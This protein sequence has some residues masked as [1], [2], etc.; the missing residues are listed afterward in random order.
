MPVTPVKQHHAHDFTLKSDTK[1]DNPFFVDL[2][3]TFTHEGGE[4]IENLPGFYDGDGAWKVRFAPTL[5]GKWT[6]V[7]ASDDPKLDGV[8]LPAVECA[9]NDNPA[10][11]GVLGTDPEYSHR[12]AWS[13][14][15]PYI[16]MG[17]ECDWLFAYHQ[18][19]GDEKFREAMDLVDERGFNCIIMNVYAHLGFS[20]KQEPAEHFFNP[21]DMYVFEGTNDEPDHGRLNLEFFQDFDQV[22]SYLHSKGIVAHL[23]IQVQNKSVKW[24]KRMTAED[25][26]YWRYVVARYQAY[27]N[28]VWDTSKESYNLL[29][30]FPEH[31]YVLDRISFIRSNDA[32]GHLVTVHDS[33]KKSWGSVSKADEATDFISDQIH[34]A[35]PD[36]Y[37][38][39][40]IRRWRVQHRPYVNLEYGYELGAEDIPTYRG[41][42]TA[43]WEKM[44]VW[45]YAIHAAGAYPG[46]YYNNTSWDLVK[47]WPEPVS[48]K[49]YR[50]MMDF[51]SAMDLR[52]MAPDN[53]F[54]DRGFCL[55]ELG[56]QYFIFCPDGGNVRLDLTAVPEEGWTVECT[57]LDIFTGER[58][59]KELDAHSFRA[60]LR[61]RLEYTTHPCAIYVKATEA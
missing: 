47:F 7:T 23:M 27:G 30:H 11:H 8:K 57:W 2:K 34:L 55:A 56:K 14:G 21:P 25:D 61:N 43:E 32:Y 29:K 31:A 10:V 19:A 39:E 38:R 45:T 36:A 59:S 58:A 49:R 42:T 18:R 54:V 13:D 48:W 51:L 12:F 5:Q 52:P 40:A 20:R 46:Y 3:A 9:A 60:S 53:D 4:K 33:E 35:D 22:M 6:G 24:P 50:W 44:L 37:N 26:L 16:Y 28:V 41:G 17:F 1:H 15:N